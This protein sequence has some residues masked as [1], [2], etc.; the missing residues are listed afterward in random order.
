ML[1]KNKPFLVVVIPPD[2][3]M[4]IS[5]MQ[6]CILEGWGAHSLHKVH[7]SQEH[8]PDRSSIPRT[9]IKMLAMVTHASIV[10]ERQTQDSLWVLLATQSKIIGVLQG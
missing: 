10:L 1:V 9:Y 3:A 7:P 5:P 6:E 4:D 2:Y 8:R